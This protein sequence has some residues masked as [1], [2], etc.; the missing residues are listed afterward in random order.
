VITEAAM[1]WRKVPGK[2]DGKVF[3]IV[4][5]ALLA[6]SVVVS[7]ALLVLHFHA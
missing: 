4:V 1:H 6:A 3:Y 2:T 7:T 5:S